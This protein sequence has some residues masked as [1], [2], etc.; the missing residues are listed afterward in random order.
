MNAIVYIIVVAVTIVVVAIPKGLPPA[1][2]L[3]KSMRADNALVRELF[4]C[5]T[6]GSATTICPN[7]TYI[8]T[9]IEL[10]VTEF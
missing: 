4:A 2:I 5:E 1:I 3:T 7:K 6:M 8:L 10:K 9:L